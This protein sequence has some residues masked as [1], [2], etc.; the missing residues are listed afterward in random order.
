MKWD[1]PGKSTKQEKRD[2]FFLPLPFV[3]FRFSTDWMMPTH[4]RKSHPFT[5]STSS[6]A[7]LNW[8]HPHRHTQR[9]CLTWAPG[10]HS[11][12]HVK[13]T[14]YVMTHSEHGGRD[15]SD[16]AICPGTPRMLGARKKLQA[17]SLKPSESMA[18]LTPWFQ[19]SGLQNCQRIDFC[20]FKPPG[21]WYFIRAETNTKK[22][23]Q[24]GSSLSLLTASPSVSGI[25]WTR[26]SSPNT[27]SG[28]FPPW[29]HRTVRPCLENDVFYYLLSST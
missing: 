21:L 29:Q 23:T 13:L 3:P 2:G 11:G 17:S 26:G 1:V 8:N 10:A 4:T 20:G 18:L 25:P 28:H 12:W 19:T 7:V 5:E 15:W 16:A 24:R 14:N 22:L 27:K 6:S 9:R